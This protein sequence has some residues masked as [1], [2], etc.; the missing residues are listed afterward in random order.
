[1]QIN[2][3]LVYLIIYIGTICYTIAAYFHLSLKDWTFLKAFFI[4]IC[5][6][7]LEYQF[8]LRGNYWA[9][10]VL[11]INPIQILVTTSVFYFINIWIL[12]KLILKNPVKIWRE[13]LSFAF[14]IAAIIVSNL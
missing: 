8:S 10:K 1:M 13:L 14:I 3:L 11:Q 12:N 5:F 6:V 9:N 2:T 4:A 7:L